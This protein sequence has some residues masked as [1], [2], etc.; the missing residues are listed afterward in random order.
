MRF[1][2]DLFKKGYKAGYQA[3]KKKLNES[4]EGSSSKFDQ[5][6]KLVYSVSPTNSAW[7]KG[8]AEYAEM[9]IDNLED[10]EEYDP[11]FIDSINVQTPGWSKKLQKVLLDGAQDWKESSWGGA[12]KIYDR[13]IAEALCSPSELRKT[14]GGRKRPNAREEWLDVQARALYQAAMRVEEAFKQL[15]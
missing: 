10:H 2:R 5:L 4:G 6:R 8:V 12:W 15:G 11:G 13:D 1:N 3:A 14:D 9:M 7:T